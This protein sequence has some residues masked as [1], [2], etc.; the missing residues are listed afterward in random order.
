MSTFKS[1]VSNDVSD[2]AAPAVDV[3]VQLKALS[4][5]HRLA[6]LQWLIDPR[7]HF[8]DQQDADLVEDGVCVGFITTKAGLT[9]PTVTSHMQIL[10][11][12][13]LVTSKKIKNWVYY[14][15]NQSRIRAFLGELKDRLAQP[16]IPNG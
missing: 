8:P 3:V 4:N 10:A 1:T 5:P 11:K 7:V 14:R 2:K 15:P 12:A 6:I 16:S 9:Q 13:D